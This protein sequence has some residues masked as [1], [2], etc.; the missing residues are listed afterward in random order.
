MDAGVAVG[1]VVGVLVR[2]GV[3]AIISPRGSVL[4][5]SLRGRKHPCLRSNKVWTIS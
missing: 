1:V 3:G 4:L 5:R 2:A